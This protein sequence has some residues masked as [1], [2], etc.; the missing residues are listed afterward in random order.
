MT[1]PMKKLSLYFVLLTLIASLALPPQAAVATA[2]E[3]FI[4]T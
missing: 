2:S 1:R 4:D 3:H